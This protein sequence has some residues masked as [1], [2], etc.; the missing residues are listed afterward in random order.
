M[1]LHNQPQDQ[2]KPKFYYNVFMQWSQGHAIEV[3]QTNVQWC[4]KS[5]SAHILTTNEG[6]EL[7][8]PIV[9]SSNAKIEANQ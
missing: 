7:E 5:Q 1:C 2:A 4:E 9:K 6:M 8:D 3:Y